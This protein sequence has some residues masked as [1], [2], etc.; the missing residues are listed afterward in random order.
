MGRVNINNVHF[1]DDAALISKCRKRP[2][3]VSKQGK[4][5]ENIIWPIAKQEE[6]VHHG[7]F[8]K[9]GC[10][11]VHHPRIWDAQKHLL[12][13]PGKLIEKTIN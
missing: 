7:I 9:E 3:G 5:R 13:I 12:K 11:K 1:A 2:S 4:G 6:N 10:S 8:E